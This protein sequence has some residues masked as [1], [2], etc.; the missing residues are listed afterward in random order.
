M[1]LVRLIG[2]HDGV[3]E[4][5]TVGRQ[6]ELLLVG[7]EHLST[8]S[9]PMRRTCWNTEAAAGLSSSLNG[10]QAGPPRH[11][12]ED[13]AVETFSG[14]SH[15]DHS[16]EAVGALSNDRISR[17][18]AVCWGWRTGVLRLRRVMTA[19]GRMIARVLPGFRWAA[20]P[21]TVEGRCPAFRGW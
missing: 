10:G 13:A 5:L 3:D 9:G 4:V 16:V 21:T 20:C 2:G 6:R 18:T 11:S 19:H 14:A 12:S 1:A 17:T 7:I 15:D 8:A